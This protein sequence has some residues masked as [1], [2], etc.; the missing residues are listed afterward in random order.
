MKSKHKIV[1]GMCHYPVS[2]HWFWWYLAGGQSVCVEDGAHLRR[3]DAV[4]AA[5][6]FAAKFIDP[7]E[8]VVE[9]E[10]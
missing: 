1:V 2:N 6:R 9:K 4:R 3:S 8:V 5:R 7:P 10:L